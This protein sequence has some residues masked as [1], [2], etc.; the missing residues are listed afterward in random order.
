MGHRIYASLTLIAAALIGSGA[1]QADSGNAFFGVGLT[2]LAAKPA[3]PAGVIYR[4]AVYTPGAV[5]IGLSAQGY[6]QVALVSRNASGYVFSAF[7]SAGQRYL[8]T[9]AAWRGE[10]VSAVRG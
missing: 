7:S 1:A 2:V 9:V 5:A 10:I 8:L 3:A 6:S 4:N